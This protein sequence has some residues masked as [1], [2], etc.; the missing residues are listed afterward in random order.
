MSII[1]SKRQELADLLK[2]INMSVTY[3]EKII[4]AFDE[5]ADN[6][7]V[8][9]EIPFIKESIRAGA[10]NQTRT[11]MLFILLSLVEYENGAWRP[12]PRNIFIDTISDFSAFVRFYKKAT[13][14][15]G[16]GKY[17]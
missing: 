14:K 1:A 17:L 15:E 11:I 7:A 8:S 6:K 10:S 4:S 3:S 2:E 9:F 5:W 13:S 16:Y 12:F